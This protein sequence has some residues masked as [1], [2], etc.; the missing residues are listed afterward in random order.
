[1]KNPMNAESPFNIMVHR[2]TEL[3]GSAA[4][5]KSTS[6]RHGV[7]LRLGDILVYEGLA[8]AADVQSALHLQSVAR[9]Y[10][11]LG[12]ILVAQKIITR[13]QLLSVLERHQRQSKLGELLVK[14]KALTTEQLATALAEQRRRK[15]ALGEIVIRLKYVTEEQL[16]HALCLQLHISFFDLDTIELD[17]SLRTL[18][19]PRFA[20]KGLVVPVARVGN[21][22]VVAMDD[23]TRT[24]VIE[25]IKSSTGFAIEIITSTRASIRRALAHMYPGP[26]P[27]EPNGL[28]PR[29]NGHEPHPLVGEPD[30]LSFEEIE[31]LSEG[32][33]AYLDVQR[34]A[35]STSGIVRQLLTLAVERGA[36]DIHLEAVD[37]G[38]QTRF[39]IDGVLQELDLDRVDE[40]LN[41]NRGKLMSRLKIL[42]K[43]D[44]AERRR[45][46]DGSFRA[47]VERD[48]ESATV[49][50]RISIIPGYYGE[51]AVI[52]I[53]DPR[54]LPQSVEGLGLREPVAARLRQ[55]LRSSTG[56]ILVTG[57]TGS[58]KSTT[59]FGALKSVYQPGIKILT[60]ENPIEY[61]C[62]GFRQHEV[63]DR[64]GNTF[65]KY[66]RSFLRHDPDVI[67][68]GEIRDGET[69]ELAFRAAQTGH[70]VLSTLHTN[71]TISALPRLLDLGV[72]AN[73]ITSSLLGVL[74]QRLAREVCSECRA[75]YT[76]PADLLGDILGTPPAD[77]RWYRGHG[78]ARCNYTGYRGRLILTELWT[79]NDADIMLI[80]RGAPFEEIRQ[81]ARKTTLPMADDAAE[82][83]C[84]GR[85]NLEELIRALPHSALRQL[86]LDAI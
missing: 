41:Q 67:M 44:I 14:T 24:A 54:G 47:R 78:C 21:T 19:N 18:I 69:A 48:G 32:R 57:P 64:L 26:V 4:V 81:S 60:A 85:T 15:Q 80:N 12:H 55:L 62:D 68:V 72:D 7:S 2:A 50:F 11:P 74:S 36:S 34:A 75:Q 42:S 58:G 22:L 84:Q 59:L 63:D 45:P 20:R 77:F 23:P 29:P 79:P 33:A 82:K 61:V 70:L 16:R 53:L 13:R 39:R 40:M 3:N 31:D 83:L 5:R 76:P 86:R 30:I 71:D 35:E 38:I 66:L 28:A 17:R 56:I 73:L 65:A 49:D 46:Q 1:M 8:T 6:R 10:I 43:L 37:R 25:D 52:R 51:S 9:T 27:A